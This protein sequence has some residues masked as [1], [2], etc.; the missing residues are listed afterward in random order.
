ME[1]AVELDLPV[2][3]ARAVAWMK[4]QPAATETNGADAR[5]YEA[6]CKLRDLGVSQENALW[7][8]LDHYKCQPQDGRYQAF[9][10][11]KLANAFNYGQNAPGASG[12]AAPGERYETFV[13]QPDTPDPASKR[14]RFRLLD[15]ADMRALPEP[16]YAIQDFIP[17]QGITLVYGKYGSFK[18]FIVLDALVST[19]A[20][21]PA[22]GKLHTT[23]GPTVYCAAEA[24]FGVARKRV[25]ALLRARGIK[26]DALPFRLVQ[27]V[28]LAS[29]PEH[30]QEFVAQVEAS[31]LKPRIVCFDTVARMMGSLDENE[32]RAA[33]LVIA[34]AERVRD[35]LGCAVILLHHAGKNEDKGSRGSSA[36]PA[37]VDAVFQ[38]RR[39]PDTLAVVVRCDGKMKDADEPAPLFLLG[40][41]VEQSLAFHSVS[42]DEHAAATRAKPPLSPGDVGRALQRLGATGGKAVTTRVLARTLAEEPATRDLS[43]EAREKAIKAMEKRLRNGADDRLAAYVGERGRGRGTTTTWTIPVLD[44]EDAK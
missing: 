25:P 11:R 36:L 43:E 14:S 1:T 29:V 32:A 10:E 2:N 5:T 24:P 18:S 16:T 19:A 42:A 33:N 28:P 38:V 6:A 31:G 3:E 37:G 23:Q 34:A 44:A 40:Q 9:L 17:D 8:M 22:F 13:G 41:E 7:L 30:A 12:L 26:D 20:G 35:A 39:T 15:L 21:I 27:S 4:A